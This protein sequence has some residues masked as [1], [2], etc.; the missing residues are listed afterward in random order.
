MAPLLGG[1]GDGFIVFGAETPPSKGM[2][3]TRACVWGFFFILF[4]AFLWGKENHFGVDTSSLKCL[5]ECKPIWFNLG[6]IQETSHI[7]GLS[8]LMWVGHF[9]ISINR[10]GSLINEQCQS[11]RIPAG[12][13][14][15]QKAL[16]VGRGGRCTVVRSEGILL[17]IT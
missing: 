13:V 8:N 2:G 10:E 14:A 16:A 7:T 5:L 4:V 17:G 11:H 12:A 9:Q 3:A 15:T 1:G 6:Y